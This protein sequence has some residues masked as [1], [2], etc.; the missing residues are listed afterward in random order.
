MSCRLHSGWHEDSPDH[1]GDIDIWHV[2]SLWTTKFLL[3]VRVDFLKITIIVLGCPQKCGETNLYQWVSFSFPPRVSRW[4]T[5]ELD[6]VFLIQSQIFRNWFPN[7]VLSEVELW[8]PNALKLS[9]SI[10]SSVGDRFATFDTH[11]WLRFWHNSF[12]FF[13]FFF[14]VSL[15]HGLGILNWTEMTAKNI[16]KLIDV[17]KPEKTVPLITVKLSSPSCE[18]SKCLNLDFGVPIDLI[19]Q[20][21]KRDSVGLGRVSS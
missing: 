11:H 7:V 1:H 2:I 12:L 20:P 14:M 18:L 6:V 8:T 9:D 19:Q 5:Q 21:I 3:N 10:E 17:E 13:W 4:H 16:E 15:P